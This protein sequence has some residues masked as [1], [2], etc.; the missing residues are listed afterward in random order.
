ML[1]LCIFEKKTKDFKADSISHLRIQVIENKQ[2]LS[3]FS[4]DLI[5]LTPSTFWYMLLNG[6]RQ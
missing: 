3:K 1:P 5:N 2:A 6:T 4:R